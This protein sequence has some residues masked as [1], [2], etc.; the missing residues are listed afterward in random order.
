MEKRDKTKL[1]IFIILRLQ[2]IIAGLIAILDRN[3]TYLGM[4][5]L[6]FMVMLLPSIIDKRLNLDISSKFEI[7]LVAFIYA[8]LFL[9]EMHRFYDK[10]WWWDKM[11]HGFSG[12]IIGN[13]GLIII[14]Y[15][16]SNSKINMNL[17]PFFVSFFVF[18]FSLSIG[19]IW[20]IYEY[21]MDK[22]FGF[23]MQRGSLDDTMIDIIL[24]AAGALIF[25]IIGYFQQ[26]GKIDLKNFFAISLNRED[27]MEN[28][29][30]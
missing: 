30:I 14:S 22:F 1:W 11:L 21:A 28:E 8:S 6:T 25:S 5:I 29:A 13:I 20:E 27:N 23:F 2:I 24:D 12:L 17:S 16:N 7:V 9:G 10:F 4:S 19:A 26:K 18:C 3:W 15:L